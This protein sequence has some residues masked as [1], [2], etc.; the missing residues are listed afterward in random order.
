MWPFFYYHLAQ[1]LGCSSFC[2][3]WFLVS[4]HAVSAYSLGGNAREL[5]S[6]PPSPLGTRFLWE[7]DREILSRMVNSLYSHYDALGFG[8]LSWAYWHA[9]CATLHIAIRAVVKRL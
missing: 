6:M 1:P 9:V 3:K 4:F 8:K 2:E 7:I 5:P